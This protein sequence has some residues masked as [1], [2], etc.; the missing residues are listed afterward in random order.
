MAAARDAKDA[1]HTS[2]GVVRTLHE[3]AS[4]FFVFDGCTHTERGASVSAM[5]SDVVREVRDERNPQ[6]KQ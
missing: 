3:K 5:V 4:I 6:C 2:L 1:S